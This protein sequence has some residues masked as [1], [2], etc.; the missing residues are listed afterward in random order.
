MDGVDSKGGAG[1]GSSTDGTGPMGG[2]DSSKDGIDSKG[3]WGGMGLSSVT[4]G[5]G[6][7]GPGSVTDGWDDMGPSS[8]I[9]DMDSFIDSMDPWSVIDGGGGPYIEGDILFSLRC[10]FAFFFFVLAFLALAFFAFSAFAL[11]F[12]AFSA[13]AFAFSF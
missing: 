7:A 3:G 2:D 12:F 1:P 4:G 10:F 11:A 9:G 13:F 6:G 5:M 8:S